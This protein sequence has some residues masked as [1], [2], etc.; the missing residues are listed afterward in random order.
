MG[1]VTDVFSQNA[2]GTLDVHEQIVERVDYVP[3]LLGQMGI[4]EPWYSRSKTLGIADKNKTVKLINTSERGSPPEEYIPQGARVRYFK[5]GRLAEGSTV[6]ADELQDV[7]QLPFES[8][9]REVSA[10]IADRTAGING[11]LDLTFEHMRLGAVQGKVY[12]ADGTLLI[13]WFDEWGASAPASVS[14]E[15]DVAE[16]DIR[17]VSRDIKRKMM[18]KAKGRWRAGTSIVNLCGDNFFD[19]LV[20]HPL[21]KETK[22][23]NERTREL[24]N[25]EGY[26]AVEYE[27]ILHVNYRGTDD[28][29]TLSIP[30]NEGRI[31]P[32]GG[33]FFQAAFAPASEFKPYVNQRARE[34]Y[35]MLLSDPSGREEWD[36]V[37]IY[38]YPLMVC[39][40]PELLQKVTLT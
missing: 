16:T 28:G 20:S 40:A 14:F 13:D 24:E 23:N 7:L 33:G 2:W 4:F 8:Q 36:R 5:P 10:E 38:S 29:T 39:N 6:Y 27:G 9:F 17:K 18:T 3:G 34:R 32:R 11:D 25:I 37:E 22:V 15:L 12:D 1:I 21:Y 35:T 31:F 26:S 30:S 19:A